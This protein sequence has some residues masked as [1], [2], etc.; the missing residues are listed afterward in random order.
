MT[1]LRRLGSAVAVSTTVLV[2]AALPANAAPTESATLH[3]GTSQ[4]Q[5]TGFG[6]GQVL[7]VT[8]SKS[9]FIVTR[10]ELESGQTV[11]I[12]PGHTGADNIVSCT[13]TSP[14]GTFFAF[15]GFF[16]PAS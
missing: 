3:C 11:F 4:L 7:H 8:D 14:S 13:V 16:T 5:V 9:R 1:I 10:A 15:E 12:A 2:V 6:R